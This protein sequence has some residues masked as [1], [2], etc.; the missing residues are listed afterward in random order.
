MLYRW[1]HDPQPLY[2]PEVDSFR[3][4]F[5][6]EMR[7]FAQCV[8]MGTAPSVG[9][10]EQ[11]RRALELALASKQSCESGDAIRLAAPSA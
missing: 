7:Y 1:G 4:A 3:I 10:A 8:R 5:R 2:T 6:E 9:T 11:A